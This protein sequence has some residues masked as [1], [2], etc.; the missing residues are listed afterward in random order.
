M[1]ILRDYIAQ[2]FPL[3]NKSLSHMFSFVIR[4]NIFDMM[5]II[6]KL[7]KILKISQ[8]ILL[9]FF[10]FSHKLNFIYYKVNKIVPKQPS[11]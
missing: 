3:L 2:P 10:F 7:K 6:Y 5:M 1:N 11:R 4:L 8:I 9:F